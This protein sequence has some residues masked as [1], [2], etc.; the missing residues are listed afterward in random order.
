MNEEYYK[1]V[2]KNRN[3]LCVRSLKYKL[4]YEKGT[5][6]N[7]VEGSIGIFIFRGLYNTKHYKEFYH[8]NFGSD[9]SIYKI[10]KVKP[11][12]ALHFPN[13][14]CNHDNGILKTE[15]LDSFYKNHYKKLERMI[16]EFVAT[17]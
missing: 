7:K 5:I 11:I 8:K 14:I 10:I 1:I 2:T 12:G 17:H 13:I 3:S 15:L 6:V 9:Y 4:K 16:Q